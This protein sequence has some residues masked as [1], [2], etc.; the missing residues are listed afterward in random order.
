MSKSIVVHLKNK[1]PDCQVYASESSISVVRENEEILLLKK[2]AHG[3]FVDVSEE[4]GYSERFDLAPIPKEARLHK[5]SKDGKICKDELCEERKPIAEAI[6][7]KYGKIPSVDELAKV[8]KDEKVDVR[9]KS[10]RA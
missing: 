9:N 7:R 10:Y 8:H 6:F 1:Y 4:Y 5:L 3:S 2:D